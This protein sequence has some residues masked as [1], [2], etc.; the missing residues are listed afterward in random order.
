MDSG[1]YEPYIR[2]MYGEDH[3]DAVTELP[4]RFTIKGLSAS[5]TI[6]KISN[7]AGDYGTFR[8]VRGATINAVVYSIST[9]FY[10]SNKITF[11]G[12][13]VT[14]EGD[15]QPQGVYA[16]V[17]ANSD[18]KTVIQTLTDNNVIV[19]DYEGTPAWKDYQFYPTAKTIVVSDLRKLLPLLKQKFLIHTADNGWDSAA[20]KNRIL[21][22]VGSESKAQDYTITDPL[23]TMSND[24]AKKR[25]IWRDEASTV[26]SQGATNLPIHN[27]GFLLS[28]AT[29][30]GNSI[31]S[32]G[33]SFSSK[34]AVHLKYQTGDYVNINPSDDGLH[35]YTGRIEVEEVLDPSQTPAWHNIIR[36]LEFFS[37]TE[38]GPL[39]STIEAAAPYTPLVTGFFNTILSAN[40]NNIQAA[41]ETLDDHTHAGGGYTDEQAQDAVGA[42]VDA[43][44]TYVDAT[45]L[46]QRAALTGDVTASAGSNT[47]TVIT[48]ST[49]QAGKVELATTTEINTGTDTTR[50]MPVDQFV[51]STRNVRYFLIRVI[52][53]TTNVST[54]NIKGGDV[55]VPFTGTITEVGAYG[56]TAG[57]TGVQTVDINKNGTTILSTKIT[58]DTT[59]KSSRTAATPPVISVSSISAGDLLTID[60]DGVQTTPAK[61]LTVILGIRQL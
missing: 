36:P 52:D 49:T 54:G 31:F 44:L 25:L 61:G 46:L 41:M 32:Y 40:D 53:A 38:A 10:N 39:P 11:N 50:A 12:K 29:A 56:D 58:I 43:S 23:F 57:T 47:T 18:Y 9:M 60:V 3:N 42:M 30:P 35:E 33:S 5:V 24:K 8:L 17:A 28:T 14:L 15:Y 6:P 48:T 27:L 22:F 16:T 13:F 26:H 55:E 19:I 37:N 1:S 4:L 51:A 21:F 2:C 59:E 20:G 7:D 45:P 34:I